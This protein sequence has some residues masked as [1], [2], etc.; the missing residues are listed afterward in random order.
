M[1]DFTNMN[2][3]LTAIDDVT[4]LVGSNE[5]GSITSILDFLTK[6][7][8]FLATVNSKIEMLEMDLENANKLALEL[9][10]SNNKLMKKVITSEEDRMFEEEEELKQNDLADYF[11]E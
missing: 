8:E 6:S 7:K 1:D 10:S 11:N 9:R 2:E 3:V 5:E 4:S